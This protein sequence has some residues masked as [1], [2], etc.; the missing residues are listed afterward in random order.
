MYCQD[1]QCQNPGERGEPL[2]AAAGGQVKARCVSTV[3]SGQEAANK[4]HLALGLGDGGEPAKPS[5]SQT[6]SI[7]QQNVDQIRLDTVLAVKSNLFLCLS[8]AFIFS[9]DFGHQSFFQY[10]GKSVNITQLLGKH[11]YISGFVA[12]VCIASRWLNVDNI[13]TPFQQKN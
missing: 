7:T 2:A 5:Y 1:R 11:P 4:Q 9:C 6:Q 8:L 3:Y 12:Q 13:S 10:E